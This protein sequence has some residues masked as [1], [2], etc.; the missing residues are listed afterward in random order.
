MRQV[1]IF[2][3]LTI[4]FILL[5]KPVN[6]SFGGVNSVGPFTKG[7]GDTGSR[8]WIELIG[9]GGLLS[10]KPK[11]GD[12]TLIT[13]YAPGIDTGHLIFREISRADGRKSLLISAPDSLSKNTVRATIYI[14][15]QS[16]NLS[17]LEYANGQW[18]QIN[19]Q[20]LRVDTEN[21]NKVIRNDLL[22]FS[23]KGFGVYALHEGVSQD[24]SVFPNT[25][26]Y[27]SASVLLGGSISRG[28]LPFAWSTAFLVIGWIISILAHK[29]DLIREK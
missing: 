28:L 2:M 23:V 17:L 19:P 13:V 27:P 25:S 20:S 4:C 21:S 11:H 24:L 1:T 10:G 15:P 16:V 3:L 6:G 7:T 5:S 26:R 18:K 12:I 8:E 29:R 9:N 22:A 14:K